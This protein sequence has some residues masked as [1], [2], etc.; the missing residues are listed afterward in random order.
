MGLYIARVGSGDLGAGCARL[1][2]EMDAGVLVGAAGISS[3]AQGAWKQTDPLVF[4][5]EVDPGELYPLDKKR[6]EYKQAVAAAAQ[7]VKEHQ[8]A[9]GTPPQGVLGFN[10]PATRLCCNPHTTP[11]CTCTPGP[12][13]VSVAAGGFH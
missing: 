13:L 6:D 2:G 3:E 12:A 1:L 10:D 8:D 4:Q 5:I 11:P 7:A 9:L